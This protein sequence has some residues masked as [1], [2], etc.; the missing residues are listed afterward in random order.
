MK[1]L[2]KIKHGEKVIGCMSTGALFFVDDIRRAT[3]LD[4]K[5]LRSVLSRLL[6]NGYLTKNDRGQWSVVDGE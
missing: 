3:S 6:K 4:D 5:T 2:N 1:P